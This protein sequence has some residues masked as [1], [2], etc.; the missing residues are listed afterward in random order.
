MKRVVVSREFAER[1]E[2]PEWARVGRVNREAGRLARAEYL[3]ERDLARVE[4]LRRAK[5]EREALRFL[6]RYA[7][8][9]LGHEEQMARLRKEQRA[10]WKEYVRL[11]EDRANNGPHGN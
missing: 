1:P 10:V 8:E 11:N 5:A 7:G 9:G 3:L 2:E 6:A 4:A